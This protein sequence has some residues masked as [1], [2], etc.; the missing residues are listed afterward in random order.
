MPEGVTTA[1][2]PAPT[3]SAATPAAPARPGMGAL[4]RRILALAAPT[5]LLAAVQSFSQLFET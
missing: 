3:A 2:A 1:A 5:T 4:L